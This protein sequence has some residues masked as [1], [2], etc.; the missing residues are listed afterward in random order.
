MMDLC[1]RLTDDGSVAIFL[2]HGVIER[3]LHE[4]RNYTRK[5]LPVDE[6]R[7]MLEGLGCYGIPLS[8][9]DVLDRCRRGT[10]FP[11]GAFAITFDDGFENNLTVARP[12]LDQLGIPATIYVTTR[13]IDENGMSWI[14]RIELALECTPSGDLRLP[15]S[16]VPRA[17][18][19]RGEKIEMLREIRTHVKS[20]PTLDVDQF[21][22]DVYRQ[23]GREEVHGTLDPLDKKLTWDQ[24]ARWSGGGFIIGG[25]SHTHPILSFLPQDRL[26]EEVDTSISLLKY[27]AGIVSQH[28]SYPEGLSHCYSQSVIDVLKTRGIA[29]CPTAIDGTNLAN[30]DPFHLRRIMVS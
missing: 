6:F 4:V 30:A 25:H 15:W 19:S 2:F 18:G 27:K 13:F 7:T 26:V 24:V 14:D 29:C 23:L 20:N 12:V 28:Y 16:E 10:A 22:R 3:Q 8:M 17:F 11:K 5:H 9:D 1:K 21:V